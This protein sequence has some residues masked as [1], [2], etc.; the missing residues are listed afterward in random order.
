MDDEKYVYKTDLRERSATARSAKHQGS[1][2]R[3]GC[4]LPSDH[5]TKKEK[6]AMT[7][8]VTTI[9]PRK[10]M[11][12]AEFSLLPK[13]QQ[14]LYCELILENYNI[15]PTAFSRM[16]G[17]SRQY[18]SQVLRAI[19][20]RYG[21]KSSP[22][23]NAR[24]LADYVHA[25][26]TE[27]SPTLR[28]AY[29]HLKSAEPTVCQ[30]PEMPADTVKTSASSALVQASFTLS[31][32]FHVAEL[33]QLLSGLITEGDDVTVEISVVKVAKVAE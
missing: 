12:W 16:F 17:I 10:P 19:G 14:A 24:F 31:G 23:E 20:V 32:P 8:P 6:Q 28:G 27:P 29:S 26:A 4:S 33:S 3:R 2:R 9:N 22:T 21:S 30:G 7:G 11:A 13:D 18:C 25:S 1:K 5:M 15:G